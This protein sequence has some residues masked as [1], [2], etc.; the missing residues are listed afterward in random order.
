MGSFNKCIYLAAI[1]SLGLTV[2][3][4][5]VTLPK[6][7]NFDVIA[8]WSGTTNS[9]NPTKD[10]VAGSY[11]M[12][13]TVVSMIPGG[14]G[15]QNSFRC[16]GTDTIINGRR[17]GGNICE[18]T[19]ADGD[20][21]ISTFQILPD[22]KVTRDLIGGTGKY[23][24]MTQTATVTLMPPLKDAKPGTFQGCNRQSGTYKLK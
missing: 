22:G 5:A 13:G 14:L 19:D 20:K 1:A 11:E 7:G 12:L 21:R 23:E 18:T 24:G 6:E 2:P 10:V 15:D 3:A 16:V 17:G 4:L 9:I 8:C